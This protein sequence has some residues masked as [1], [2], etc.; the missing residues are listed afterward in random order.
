MSLDWNLVQEDDVVLYKYICEEY[1]ANCP[2]GYYISSVRKEE[3]DGIE[4][5]EEAYFGNGDVE[6]G[7]F[8]LNHSNITDVHSIWFNPD[9][10]ITFQMVGIYGS[11]DDAMKFIRQNY[12]ELF[13]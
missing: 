10:Q 11:V 9:D 6:L 12:P 1:I 4:Y 7:G 3:D 13:L 5:I 8:Y 2:P